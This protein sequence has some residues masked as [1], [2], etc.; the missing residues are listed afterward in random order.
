MSWLAYLY[1]TGFTGKG[2]YS[3]DEV[4]DV[5]NALYWYSRAAEAGDPEAMEWI[6]TIY[7]NGH[8]PDMDEE[9]V[10]S[11]ALKAVETGDD[12]TSKSVM[13]DL[14]RLYQL[15]GDYAQAEEWYLRAEEWVFLGRLYTEEGYRDVEKAVEY[16]EKAAGIPD[17]GF[18]PYLASELLNLYADPEYGPRADKAAALYKLAYE[19]GYYR[20]LYNLAKL[21]LDDENDIADE[22]QGIYWMYQSAMHGDTRAQAWFEQLNPEAA[23]EE[24]AEE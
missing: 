2:P 3:G 9:Q 21:Y 20:N 7:L 17:G 8:A 19:K 1:Y 16:L 23:E 6:A 11:W 24:P 5:E 12:Y 18:V 14:G 10:I 22:A 15:R 13:T 4:R